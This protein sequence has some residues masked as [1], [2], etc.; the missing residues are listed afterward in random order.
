MGGSDR[1]APSESL[2]AERRDLERINVE[3]LARLSRVVEVEGEMAL[4]SEDRDGQPLDH[5]LS[6]GPL[7]PITALRYA[8]PLAYT[9]AG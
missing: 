5:I 4:L 7:D 3:G 1:Q 6:L 8:R 9:L 2:R